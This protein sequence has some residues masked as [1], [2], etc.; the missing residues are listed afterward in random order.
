VDFGGPLGGPQDLT[1]RRAG[2]K[3]ARLGFAEQAPNDV[4]D[5]HLRERLVVWLE[6]PVVLVCPKPVREHGGHADLLGAA[7]VLE[8]AVTHEER[9]LG[10][11][12]ER[13]EG[14]REDRGMRLALADLRG[15]DGDV[16]PL[17][18]PHTLEVS[19][20]KPPGI[21]GVRDE[22]GP[23]PPLAERVEESMRGISEPPGRLPGSVLRFEE[24]GELVVGHVDAEALEQLAHQ[25]GVLDLVQ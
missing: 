10:L 20:Q 5:V 22:A 16:E 11:D 6:P 19:V 21:E 13:I 7:D 15:E 3:A 4:E 1:S 9:A 18:Q 25:S 24:S 14:R 17:A 8:A 2:C 23:E 12:P